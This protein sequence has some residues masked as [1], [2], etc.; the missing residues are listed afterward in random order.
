MRLTAAEWTRLYKEV[1]ALANRMTY[2]RSSKAQWTSS[3]RAQE[4]VQGAF[5]RYLEVRPP[6]LETIDALRRY[7]AG[8]VRS[9]LGNAKRR[10]KVRAATEAKAVI[11]EAVVTGGAVPSAE[12]ANLEVGE[13]LAKQGRAALLLPKLRRK[14]QDA[15]DTVALR[16]I[17]CV[18][19]DQI[20]PREQ[21]EVIGCSVEEIHN[22]RKRRARA[23]KQV[24]A[25]SQEPDHD[26]DES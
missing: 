11:E 21:A 2:T 9:E 5:L 17:D 25:E 6:G 18:A 24:L 20:T 12:A 16:T 23:M 13:R 7:L 3:D 4:A 15:G 22:A 8:A 1:L 10:T 19:K 14:L 26:K